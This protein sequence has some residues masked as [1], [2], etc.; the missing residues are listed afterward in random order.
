MRT[1]RVRTVAAVALAA[2][3]VGCGGG[4]ETPAAAQRE[5]LA[6]VSI[7]PSP[8]PAS[9]SATRPADCIWCTTAFSAELSVLSPVTLS[10]VNLWL[11]GWSAGRRCL[12]AHHDTPGDGFTLA[13]GRATSVTFRHAS[14]DCAAPFTVDRVVVR[15][16]SGETLVSEGSWDV[17]LGFVE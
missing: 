5:G 17:A 12:G 3:A 15:M 10:G 13:A 6:L 2:L 11:D 14:V 7:Q 1:K 9:L 16:R 4:V 8:G